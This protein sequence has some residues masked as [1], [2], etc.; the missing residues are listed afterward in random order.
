MIHFINIV[1]YLFRL[2]IAVKFPL[3]LIPDWLFKK[4]IDKKTV[5]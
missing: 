4:Y 5:Q 3:L 1:K 2:I